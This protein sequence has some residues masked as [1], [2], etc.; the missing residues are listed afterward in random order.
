MVNILALW[1]MWSPSPPL[2]SAVAADDRG[3]NRL[4]VIQ[5]N[6]I[7]STGYGLLTPAEE[8]KE[9]TGAKNDP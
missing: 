5:E 9:M 1:A 8:G 6:I 7:W 4:V 3:A 2:Y